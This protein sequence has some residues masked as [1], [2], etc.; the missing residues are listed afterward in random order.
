MGSLLTMTGSVPAAPS[1]GLGTAIAD[2]TTAVSIFGSP[3]AVALG[4]AGSFVLI[5]VILG[6]VAVGVLRWRL[7]PWRRNGA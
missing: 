6:L 7:V 4:S 1:P 2:W 5:A 3:A